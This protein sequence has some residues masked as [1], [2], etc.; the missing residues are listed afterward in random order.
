MCDFRVG[1]EVVCVQN[2]K[3][4]SN[5][6]REGNVYEVARVWIHPVTNRAVL[7]LFGTNNGSQYR[8]ESDFWGHSAFRF[9]KVQR[10]DLTEWL[11]SSVG[12]TDK[13]DKRKRVKA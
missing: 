13:I 11:S 9:R 7:D 2:P 8:W 5:A 3:S 4:S 12:N 1:D 6:T 10:R